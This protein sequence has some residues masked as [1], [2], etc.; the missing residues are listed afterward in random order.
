MLE[1]VLKKVE[2]H[3]GGH[4]D[5]VGARVSVSD[6]GKFRKAFEEEII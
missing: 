5:A 6:L 3:G 4:E 1:N 2:G